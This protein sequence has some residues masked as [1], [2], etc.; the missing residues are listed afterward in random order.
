MKKILV[1][2]SKGMLGQDLCPTLTDNGYETT[3]TDKSNLDITNFDMAEKIISK[4]KPDYL[5]HCAAYTDVDKAEY[6]IE[7]ARAINAK[8]TENLD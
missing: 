3:E 4:E 2:G 7:S 1:T 8:G 5:I 6:D